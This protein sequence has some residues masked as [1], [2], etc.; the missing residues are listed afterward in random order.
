MLWVF[1]MVTA[2]AAWPEALP[3]ITLRAQTGQTESAITPHF[4][5]QLQSTTDE[6]GRTGIGFRRI[7]AGMAMSA[8]DGIVTG[9][10]NLDLTP[11]R[12]ELIDAWVGLNF[13]PGIAVSVGQTK[14][15]FTRYRQ[16]THRKLAFV[17]WSQTSVWFGAER[18]I[19]GRIDL[20]GPWLKGFAVSFAVGTGAN[21]RASHAVG[22]SAIYGS[23]PP[24][25]SL[26]ADGGKPSPARPALAAM[27]THQSAE[28]RSGLDLAGGPLRHAVSISGT[29]DSK[30][31]PT[32]SFAGRLGLDVVLAAYNFQFTSV[33]YMGWYA[34]SNGENLPGPYGGLV[35]MSYVI[36]KRVAPSLRYSVI[37]LSDAIVED[38]QSVNPGWTPFALSHELGG[39]ASVLLI[40]QRLMIR[41]DYAGM[42]TAGAGEE[43][44]WLHRFRFQ[45]QLR[46]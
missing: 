19:L 10:L 1:T 25:P 21:A 44:S 17:D 12:T 26:L 16:W 18:Q 7:R 45:V 30:P 14:I 37:G 32:V 3:P 28:L 5:V 39:G 35:E 43:G 15:P 33:G 6:N 31:D 2:L 8:A 29:W 24:S 27:V 22:L 23:T 4:L 40:G 38:A 41:T 42:K 13:V 20:E 46:I 36:L 9:K 11:G 34:G